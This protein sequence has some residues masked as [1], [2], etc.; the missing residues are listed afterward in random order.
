MPIFLP[1]KLSSLT[2]YALECLRRAELDPRYTVNMDAWHNPRKNEA[3]AVQDGAQVCYAGGVMAFGLGVDV[4]SSQDFEPCSFGPYNGVRLGALNAVREGQVE[5]ALGV[6]GVQD[7]R[8]P[9]S[10]RDVEIVPY[11]FYP[12]EFRRQQHELAWALSDAG[13]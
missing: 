10:L 11:N 7:R 1:M 6:M 5:R 2:F 9:K 13:F 12:R 8:L 4:D 3:T